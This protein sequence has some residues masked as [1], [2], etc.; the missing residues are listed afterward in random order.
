MMK[1][2]I[3]LA[4]LLRLDEKLRLAYL[5]KE[6]FMDA[7]IKLNEWLELVK[8]YKIEQFSYLANTISN[9]K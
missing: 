5:L 8:I 7:E 6:K 4:N 9:W 1:I 2:K 3:K